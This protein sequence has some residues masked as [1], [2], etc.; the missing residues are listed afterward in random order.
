MND[1]LEFFVT[2]II[3][4]FFVAILSAGY[5]VALLN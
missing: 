1:F 2:F 3:V 4:I 5:F